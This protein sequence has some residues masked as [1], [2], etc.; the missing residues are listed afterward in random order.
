MKNIK[1][2][3]LCSHL[4]LVLKNGIRNGKPITWKQSPCETS[5]VGILPGGAPC[6]R[7]NAAL[8]HQISLLGDE[9]GS[10]GWT[11]NTTS[12]TKMTDFQ[13]ELMYNHRHEKKMC[14]NI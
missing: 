8:G 10:A 11:A 12:V 9:M 7:R 13:R 3:V 14:S 5:S 2:G 1:N 6:G 4:F